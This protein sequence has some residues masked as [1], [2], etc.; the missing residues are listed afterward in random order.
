MPRLL[1]IFIALAG[2]SIAAPACTPAKKADAD[3]KVAKDDKKAKKKAAKKK[4]DLTDNT[5]LGRVP[6][7]PVALVD[8]D[9]ISRKAFMDVFSLKLKKYEERD[10]KIPRSADRRYR[11]SIT[12]RLIYQ[13]V[14][15]RE[16]KAQGVEYDKAKLAER[17]ER[18]RKG[19]DDWAKRLSRRGE[20][21]E[22]LREQFIATLREQ[23]LLEKSGALAVSD[24]D[25][26]AEYE[27]LKPTYEDDKD[28]VRASH[29]MVAVGPKG[30]ESAKAK[31]EASEE[32]KKKWEEAAEKKAAEVHAKVTADGADFQALAKELS[33]GPSAGRGGD[34]GVFNRDRMVKEFSDAAFKLKPGSV[35][36]PVRTKFGF[37]IIK[38]FEKYPPGVLPLPA[39]QDNI[40]T[41]L[42]GRKLHEGKRKLKEELLAKYKVE[43]KMEAHLGPDPRK[44]R[45][46]K[47][48]EEKA[49]AAK[50]KE[51]VAS[52]DK[53]AQATGS[54]E[55]KAA[56]G[57]AGKDG[58]AKQAN[59]KAG[60]AKAA[61]AKA[62]D[63]KVADAKPAADDAKKAG[64]KAAE[65]KPT[66]D[67]KAEGQAGDAS[68][69][70]AKDKADGHG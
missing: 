35:S 9:P 15:R 8:G 13:E 54:D 2:L 33:D 18:Q 62:G 70:A 7:G 43:N 53:P 44:E 22:T 38:V 16:A 51:A 11:K 23:A 41:R 59:A 49:K 39:V 52:A 1:P 65:A 47:R 61:D 36:K 66:A 67:K 30:P 17:E 40:K 55:A 48:A 6:D 34:L 28:R 58:G 31:A 14:L 68:K 26:K 4:S 27:R 21:D 20:S 12:E 64:A 25:I 37:H 57:A 45:R 46:K 3:K 24:E 69:T 10:R 42:E 19:V 63:A 32:E 56:E 29:I 60:D 5:P 50:A